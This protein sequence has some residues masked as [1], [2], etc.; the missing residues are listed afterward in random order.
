LQISFAPSFVTP[1]YNFP[2]DWHSEAISKQFFAN[3]VG[4]SYAGSIA[5]QSLPHWQNN[6]PSCSS[7]HRVLMTSSL[8]LELMPE[9]PL[10]PSP[11]PLLEPLPELS[12]EL[13]APISSGEG[14]SPRRFSV[15]AQEKTRAIASNMLMASK[16]H[17]IFFIVFLLE[18]KS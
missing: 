12:L 5:Q 8:L 14:S 6:S 1:A 13:S 2:Y 15:S 4:S 11:E 7:L 3:G 9:L 16:K 10:E 17:L 18:N